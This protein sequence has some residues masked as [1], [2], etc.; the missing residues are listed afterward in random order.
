[1]D[2][3]VDT[4]KYVENKLRI[5]AE[6]VDKCIAIFGVMFVDKTLTQP[7]YI[8]RFHAQLY[9]QLSYV[10]ETPLIVVVPVVA[11]HGCLDC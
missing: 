9:S 4:D 8:Q 6:V 11:A 10:I 7:C 5:E 1:V 2:E 3:D